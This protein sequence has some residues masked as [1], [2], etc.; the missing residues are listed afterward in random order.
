MDLG[1]SHDWDIA[2][3]YDVQ[4]REVAALNLSHDLSSFNMAAFT[5][6][7]T[8]SV[9]QHVAPSSSPSKWCFHQMCHLR[10]PESA[11]GLIVFN[12]VALTI[13]QLIAKQIRQLPANQQLQ[14]LPM[15]RV[16]MPHLPQWQ[17]LLFRMGP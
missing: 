17:A 1:R 11:S 16:S 12:A 13:S 3:E 15:P 6:I 14:L 4:Q 2:M 9:V 7:A 8:H 5:L 10:H